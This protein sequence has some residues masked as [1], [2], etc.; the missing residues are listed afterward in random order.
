MPADHDSCVVSECDNAKLFIAMQY[1]I[2]VCVIELIENQM[3]SH[4]T[5]NTRGSLSSWE[6]K[7]V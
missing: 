3:L 7:P 6:A 2:H 4:Q 1:Q 5:T